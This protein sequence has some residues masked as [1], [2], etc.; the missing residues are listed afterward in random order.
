MEKGFGRSEDGVLANLLAGEDA[1]DVAETS[2]EVRDEVLPSAE[3]T[4]ATAEEKL[5]MPAEPLP[6]DVVA[7]ASLAESAESRRMDARRRESL[8]L[9]ERVRC[10]KVASVSG[11]SPLGGDIPVVAR[12]EPPAGSRGEPRG[13]AL[14]GDERSSRGATHD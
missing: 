12:G 1:T 10:S 4:G 6:A 8:R 9:G 7:E 13:L 14:T 3:F 5:D 2:R 11:A